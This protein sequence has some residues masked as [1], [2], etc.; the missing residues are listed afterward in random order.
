MAIEN[1]VRF[2]VTK[3]NLRAIWGLP[4]WHIRQGYFD[5][6]NPNKH[7]RVRIINDERAFLGTKEGTGHSRQEEEMPIDIEAANFLFKQCSSFIEKTRIFPRYHVQGGTWTID[8][9]KKPLEGLKIAEFEH[10][11]ERDKVKLPSWIQEAKDITDSISN[12][13]LARLATEL[14]ETGQTKRL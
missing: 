3:M 6:L 5:L 11:M 8:F 2:L 13:H 9:F 12:V 10:H 1:E 14:R 7:L 4:G